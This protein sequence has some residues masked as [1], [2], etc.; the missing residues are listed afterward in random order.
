MGSRPTSKE[1]E[2]PRTY[3]IVE[4]DS[5]ID[6]FTQVISFSNVHVYNIINYYSWVAQMLSAYQLIVMLWGTD[7][8]TSIKCY[9]YLLSNFDYFII[10]FLRTSVC[11][12]VTVLRLLFIYFQF[13]DGVQN[14]IPNVW[15]AVFSNNPPIFTLMYMASL[16][17][18][19]ILHLSLPMILK[20]S[21]DFVWLVFRCSKLGDDAFKCS[22]YLSPKVLND[23]PIYSS[24]QSILSQL[25]Q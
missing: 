8:M 2:P 23:S 24:W 15:Q 18:L 16:M 11:S 3:Y 10:L 5:I 4:K 22:L 19:A 1:T 9:W 21:T 17:A 6:M 13:W 14:S 20:F 25:N 7:V 12:D